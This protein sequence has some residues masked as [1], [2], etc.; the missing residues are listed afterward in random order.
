MFRNLSSY[1]LGTLVYRVVVDDDTIVHQSD[2]LARAEFVADSNGG[3]LVTFSA[4]P[5]G[6]PKWV[7]DRQF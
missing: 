3:R 6:I 7:S 4:R 5:G 2:E 1:P